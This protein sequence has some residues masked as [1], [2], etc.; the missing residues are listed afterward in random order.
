MHVLDSAWKTVCD[1][2]DAGQRTAA[3]TARSD[4]LKGL[5]QLLR[6]LRRYENE[7]GWASTIL[8]GAALFATQ[9]AL[10]AVRPGK[11]ELLGERELPLPAGFEMTRQAGAAFANAISSR[12][13]VIALRTSA[14]VGEALASTRP[15]DRAWI[16]PISNRD[17]VVSVLF[18]LSG[19]E[20]LNTDALELIAG[21]ASAVLERGS[22]VT[23]HAQIQPVAMSDA[24]AEPAKKAALPAWSHL[25]EEQRSQH[26]RAQRFSRVKVAEMQL[27][28][29]EAC[30]EGRERGNLYLLLRPE[31]DGARE[32][33]RRQF[34]ATPTMVD[35]LHL[36]LVGTAAAGDELK[37]GAEYPGPLQ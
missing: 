11:L 22:N 29:P 27:Y 1:E 3:L 36:E 16:V 30:R 21:L 9:S 34:M 2:F 14:E 28:R 15:G 33:Y 24:P 13:T 26:V 31:I 25:G 8:D 37:L 35:Y 6:R 32:A 12:D 5:N 17:R 20:E 10:L 4:L 19:E 7:T 18:A 23:L